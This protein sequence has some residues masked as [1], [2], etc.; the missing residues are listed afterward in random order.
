M[1]KRNIIVIGASAGGFDALKKLVANL[2]RDLNASIF[3]VWH[4]SANVQGVLPNVLNKEDTLFVAN[5]V[6]MEPI[7]PG[8]IYVAPPDHHL[9]LE[10]DHMRI[11][12]GPKENRFR[13]AIDPLF[14]SA[15]YVYGS[16]VIGVI[17]SGSLDDGSAGLWAIKE[18]GGLAVVQDPLDAEVPSMPAN[19][20]K[21]V[22]AD[23][24]I[25]ILEMG[26]LLSRL[27]EETVPDHLENPK[28][29][30]TKAEIDIAMENKVLGHEVKELGELTPYTCPECHGVLS[31]LKEGERIRFRCHT[32][33]AFSIDTLIAYLT[34]SI[35]E[36][37][38][39]AIRSMQE[40][41]MLLNHM[42]DHF[43]DANQPKLAAMFFKKATDATKRAALVRE[44]VYTHENLTEES[45]L[46]ASNDPR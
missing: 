22:S 34:E 13:P 38:W 29:G 5:A 1:R 23:Y 9:I 17:L 39:N 30:L 10:D 19:A 44:A 6:D 28:N 7:Q 14:R 41:I 25:P 33:H 2:P 36:S 43:A 18:Y 31:S 46:Q 15:A 40:S 27:V 20:I 45:L 32:G 24:V 3:I 12:H 4:M 16:S 35:E 37:L 26:Q 8:R 21:A 11:T 42:G